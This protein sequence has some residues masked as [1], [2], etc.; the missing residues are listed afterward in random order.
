MAGIEMAT[1]HIETLIIGA[2]Q[3]GLATGYEL[4]RRGRELLIVDGVERVGD[5]WRR[6]WDSL[7]LFTPGK[8]NSLPGHPF[9]GGSWQ[10]SGKDE[11]AAYLETYAVVHDLPVRLRT[12]VD[13]LER[14]TE[15]GFTAHLGAETITCENVVVATGGNGCVP[16]VPEFAGHLDPNVEQLHSS[17]YR[18]PDQL[19]AGPTLVVGAANSGCEIAHELAADRPVTLSG[20]DPG[21]EPFRPGSRADRAFVP[22]FVFLARHVLTRRTPLGRRMMRRFRTHGIPVGRVRA[23]DLADR[24][25]TRSEARVVGVR[26]GRPMLADGTVV[27]VAVV[28]WCTGS[29]PDLG[30]IDL[31]VVGDDGWPRE[32]RG[33]AEDVSGLYFCGLLFQYAVASSVLPGVGRDAAYVARH[34][35]E[36]TAARAAITA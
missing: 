27:D 30:W 26:D 15:G 28:V 6:H 34:I 21:H 36:H 16:R 17:Q 33:V 1:Q 2:G 12:R 3:A 13:R 35:T 22:A 7:R 29:A 19:P 31:P 5:S 11:I 32:Y 24:G 25:V 9:P 20:R 8:Y 4:Q 10:F 14:Q 18:R 23:K